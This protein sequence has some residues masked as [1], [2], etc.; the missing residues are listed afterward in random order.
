MRSV[1]S[2]PA[3]V[4]SQVIVL[5]DEG[6]TQYL[7]TQHGSSSV[8]G[9]NGHRN[10]LFVTVNLRRRS[11]SLAS[12]KDGYPL[13]FSERVRLSALPVHFRSASRSRCAQSARSLRVPGQ[14]AHAHAGSGTGATPTRDSPAASP[15]ARGARGSVVPVGGALA[16]YSGWTRPHALRVS[17]PNSCSAPCRPRSSERTLTVPGRGLSPLFISCL[18][19]SS[20]SAWPLVL[21]MHWCR[22]RGGNG[23]PKV[24]VNR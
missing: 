21:Q 23:S 9:K 1:P 7:S 4:V 3:H 24:T 6:V 14:R 10:R 11:H 8:W 16:T 22:A 5:C 20:C 19:F 13:V 12:S 17:R 2:T 15:S 18:S